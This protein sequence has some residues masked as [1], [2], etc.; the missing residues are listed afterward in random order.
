SPTMEEGQIVRWLK[1]EGDAVSSGDVVAEVETDKATM[2]LE[3]FLEGVLL[4]RVVDEGAT[5]TVGSAIAVIGEEG[6]DVE[7][8]L[9]EF[10]GDSGA[11]ETSASSGA[12]S[13]DDASDGARDTK[14]SQPSPSER[15]DQG[16]RTPAR[17]DGRIIASPL[18]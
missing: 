1:S 11:S 15:A 8:T 6:D 9:A 3:S 7:A 4:K 13:T 17:D 5:V 14:G 18:A 2:E 16:R 10:G 12:S